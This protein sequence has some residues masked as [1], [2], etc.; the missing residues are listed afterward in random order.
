MNAI[1][2]RTWWRRI[3]QPRCQPWIALLFALLASVPRVWFALVEHP[4]GLYI[5]ADMAH[6]EACAEHLRQGAATA[7]DTFTPVGYPALLAFLFTLSHKNYVLV[8]WV[9][10]LL[11]SATGSFISL[12]FACRDRFHV[13]SRPRWSTSFYF[14]DA[15]FHAYDEAKL[16]RL[17]LEGL[18][19]EPSR[20]V[21]DLSHITDG[22]G[23]GPVSYW[24]GW[25]G[26]NGWLVIPGYFLF[27][28]C[29][30]PSCVHLV[31]LAFRRPFE[32]RE[33]AAHWL[34]W[35]VLGSTV[36]T[37]YL[38]LGDPRI[39]VPFDPL[40]IVLGA[41]AWRAFATRAQETQ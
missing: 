18:L 32:A 25:M 17:A 4:P 1:T 34:L 10:V 7:A 9:H 21:R 29:V 23:L 22:F 37:L 40:W 2:V 14:F 13:R 28:L 30:L 33:H 15:A 26:R 20:L 8:A 12:P 3:G 19:A 27:A 5:A 39:R 11:G 24:P 41:D 38:F 35:G 31:F 16:Y 36:L 6:Y